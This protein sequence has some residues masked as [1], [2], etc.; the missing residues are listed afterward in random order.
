MA[1]CL[2]SSLY[3]SKILKK[4][5]TLFSQLSC[6]FIGIL[7]TTELVSWVCHRFYDFSERPNAGFIAEAVQ[8]V[9]RTNS[10]DKDFN[11]NDFIALLEDPI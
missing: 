3:F 11:K 4:I 1:S 5:Q 10:R 8:Q 9:G 7:T 2:H 6:N